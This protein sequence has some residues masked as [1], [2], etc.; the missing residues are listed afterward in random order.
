MMSFF[1][2]TTLVFGLILAAHPLAGCTPNAAAPSPPPPRPAAPP[3]GAKAPAAPRERP[4]LD[5]YPV[6]VIAGDRLAS[7]RDFYV[8]VIGLDVIFDSSWFVA[9]GDAGG[10]HIDL[11][12]MAHDH[13]S[14]PPGPEA[15]SGRGVFFTLQVSDA[16]AAEARMVR[17]GARV[18]HPL[19]DEP[20]GQRRFMLR[21][22]AGLA[23]DV[24]EQT[25]PAAGY[26]QRYPAAGRA[27]AAGEGP[28][29]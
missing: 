2:A 11:A 13:P 26:W 18:V 5:R 25:E 8:E 27:S 6:V 15:Y 7:T 12:L 20:W 22:P 24:V 29:R 4:L 3:P 17:A 10:G 14:S 1:R 19:T 16:R 23:I 21:D 28:A 9:L